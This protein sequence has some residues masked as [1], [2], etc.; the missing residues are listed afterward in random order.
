V[1]GGTTVS[2]GWAGAE[3]RVRTSALKLRR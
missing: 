3:V 2:Y 1:P